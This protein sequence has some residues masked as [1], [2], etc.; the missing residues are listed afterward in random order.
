MAIP[1]LVSIEILY[2]LIIASI[3]IAIYL[4]TRDIYKLTKYAGISHFRN[5][6]LYFSFAYFFRLI[7]ILVLVSFAPFGR[8]EFHDFQMI[9]LFLVGYFSTMAILS[10][11]MTVLKKSDA[12]TANGMHIIATILSAV[13]F[14]LHS[15]DLLLLIQTLLFSVSV[16]LLFMRNDQ[17]RASF[18]NRVTYLLLL[19]FW[20]INLFASIRGFF[21]IDILLYI[22]SVGIFMWIYYRVEKRLEHVGKKRQVENNQ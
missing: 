4:K 20:I 8:R 12:H 22:L 9:Y 13:V 21:G 5:I 18:Q 14:F 6:F 3:C 7:M 19:G 11:T 16:L 10:V 2:T 15:Y 17:S 1:D